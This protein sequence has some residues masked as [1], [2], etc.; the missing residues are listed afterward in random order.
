MDLHRDHTFERAQFELHKAQQAWTAKYQQSDVSRQAQSTQEFVSDLIEWVAYDPTA[1]LP[2]WSKAV[3][4]S[5]RDK[6]LEPWLAEGELADGIVVARDNGRRAD[7][8]L[9]TLTGRL[10]AQRVEALANPAY[11]KLIDQEYVHKSNIQADFTT[12]EILR[13]SPALKTLT[14]VRQLINDAGEIKATLGVL[15]A[16]VR[17]GF[18]QINAGLGDIRGRIV[19]LQKGQLNLLAYA[20][21][22]EERELAR[23]KA[24]AEAAQAQLRLDAAKSSVYVL[25]TLIGFVD[26]K[27]GRDVALVGNAAIQVAD[28]LNKFSVSMAGFGDAAGKITA[29]GTAMSSAVLTGNLLAAAMSLAPVFDPNFQTPEDMI[30]TQIGALRDQVEGVRTEMHDRFDR[31]DAGL[32]QVYGSMLEGFARM[33]DGQGR[34]LGGVRRLQ[35]DLNRVQARMN[36]SRGTS[37]NWSATSGSP[38]VEPGRP[39][40]WVPRALRRPVDDLRRVLRLRERVPHVD[41]GLRVR[42]HRHRA[43]RERPAGERRRSRRRALEAPA[44]HEHRLS[45]SVR[46]GEPGVPGF[47]TGKAPNPRQW[48]SERAPP[49]PSISSGP[50]MPRGCRRAARA[51]GRRS[52]R[53][54]RPTCGAS[55]TPARPRT[56]RPTGAVRAAIRQLPRERRA[57]RGRGRPRGSRSPARPGPAA[58]PVGRP[59]AAGPQ[60]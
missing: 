33:A 10:R 57:A 18:A 48:D 40:D 42:Q 27:A 46:G 24:E 14:G 25:S 17:T 39:G 21:R 49:R 30:M 20:A 34:I 54:S 1:V 37:T 56:R 26:A 22:A 15:R 31:V 5:F 9:R 53:P 44:R 12:A 45:E 19:E 7:D 59:G 2:M 38:A 28:S 4:M 58:R 41:H 50:S 55:W 16:E 23:E 11:R 51:T 36:R 35:D 32:N 52:A 29:L 6:V 8:V 13:N 3:Q 60:R 43:R 47:L